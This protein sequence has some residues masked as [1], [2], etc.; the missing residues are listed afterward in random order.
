[1]PVCANERNRHYSGIPALHRLSPV[2]ALL[3]FWDCLN[4]AGTG[5]IQGIID[6]Y[7][8]VYKLLGQMQ[9]LSAGRDLGNIGTDTRD[10]PRKSSGGAHDKRHS[11]A[12][13]TV[14]GCGMITTAT[15]CL[16]YY[17]SI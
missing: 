3:R 10:S 11:V 16:R 13:R 14:R 7:G 5:T 9:C 15:S 8:G 2:P 12:V 4:R 1:M 17:E 6:S